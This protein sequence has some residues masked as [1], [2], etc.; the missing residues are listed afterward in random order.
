MSMVHSAE[1]YERRNEYICC[2]VQSIFIAFLDVNS[3][4]HTWTKESVN[5]TYLPVGVANI[6]DH[7]KEQVNMLLPWLRL[8]SSPPHLNTLIHSVSSVDAGTASGGTADWLV[9]E[10]LATSLQFVHRVGSVRTRWLQNKPRSWTGTPWRTILTR[11]FVAQAFQTLR[12]FL[13]WPLCTTDRKIKAFYNCNL[14]FHIV[15]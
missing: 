8:A 14:V 3:A 15:F 10:R 9:C 5:L 4:W 6:D 2:M 11:K 7:H 13:V 1:T 12:S